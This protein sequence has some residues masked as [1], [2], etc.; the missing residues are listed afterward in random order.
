MSEK[1]IK[2]FPMKLNKDVLSLKAKLKTE[3]RKRR[4]YIGKLSDQGKKRG[5]RD[6]DRDRPGM[7]NVRRGSIKNSAPARYMVTFRKSAGNVVTTRENHVT[8]T[9]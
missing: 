2:S 7:G 6:A 5:K 1:P 9:T 3:N 8:G 4:P